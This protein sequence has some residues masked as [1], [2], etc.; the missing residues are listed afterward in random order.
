M[1]DLVKSIDK[2]EVLLLIIF[3]FVLQNF[4]YKNRL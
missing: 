1:E 4:G 2:I 3:N